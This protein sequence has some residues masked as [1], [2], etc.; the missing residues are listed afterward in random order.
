MTPKR[1]VRWVGGKGGDWLAKHAH[2]LP[3][4][5]RGGRAFDV[6]AG[7]C[8]VSLWYLAQGYRVVMGDTNPRL[9]GC[10]RNLRERP[11]AVIGQLSA[12][13]SA[14]QDAADRRAD[15]YLRREHLNRLPAVTLAASALFLFILR[16][17]FNGLWREN[18]AGE[19]NTT[20]GDPSPS[21]D[22]VRADE[23]RAIAELLQNADIRHGDFEVTGADISKADA[24][25]CDAP[26]V[27]DVK[28][29][30]FTGYS[31]GGFN[32][33]DRARLAMWLRSLDKRGIRW[34][35]T[36]ARTDHALA[37]YGLCAVD[38]VDVRRSVAA[39]GSA[40]SNARELVV[41]NW[42]ASPCR[43]AMSA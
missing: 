39:K 5:R 30:A 43:A 22:I 15:F 3:L 16:A 9:I 38:E 10:L 41:R 25:F 28:G 23:L 35:A 33:N 24:A 36:D 21:K 8:S 17:G 4:P 42:G 1:L 27:P 37:T 7:G 32:L 29:K 6:F 18:A 14:Y 19:C 20:W 13:A 12:E 40:R 2:L 26:Y 34:T 11:D 31:K